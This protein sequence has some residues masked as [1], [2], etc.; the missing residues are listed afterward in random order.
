MRAALLATALI[1]LI[2][3]GACSSSSSPSSSSSSG[4][5]GDGGANADTCRPNGGLCACTS[6]C[7]S[8]TKAP[9]SMQCP[10]PPPNSGACDQECCLPAKPA[11]AGSFACGSSTCNGAEFC[12]RTIGGAQLPDGGARESDI[13]EPI[14]DQCVSDRT[15]A[16]IKSNA[17]QCGD[18]CTDDGAAHV[19]L[20]C[21]AP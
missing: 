21:L 11:D 12:S 18:Q 15:C 16:C 13:C 17:R 7:G 9:S 20:T 8:G 3:G 4:A 1:V 2:V 19:T 14:P 6:G 10:Q 5:T